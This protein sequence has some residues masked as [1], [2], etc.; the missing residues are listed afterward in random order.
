ML[1]S[2]SKFRFPSK[3]Q[4]PP[5]SSWQD[6]KA[7][8]VNSVPSLYRAASAAASSS[9]T[10]RPRRTLPVKG[11]HLR[12]SGV[13]IL[14]T[15]KRRSSRSWWMK[16]ASRRRPSSLSSRMHLLMS[17]NM[18]V[19]SVYMETIFWSRAKPGFGQIIHSGFGWY[20]LMAS[21]MFRNPVAG[22]PASKSS[23]LLGS[24]S[25]MHFMKTAVRSDVSGLTARRS[26]R[27][28]LGGADRSLPSSHAGLA[29]LLGQQVPAAKTTAR[30]VAPARLRM[31]PAGLPGAGS[32]NPG[33]RQQA[34]WRAGWGRLA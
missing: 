33:G 8:H 18:P 27:G 34:G 1:H 24:Y 28:N 4:S 7:G 32:R 3:G 2:I 10:S 29:S 11:L 13:Q 17:W 12:P 15:S 25:S 9:G 22:G 16:G 31:T 23:E 5:S 20:G 19:A 21:D 26:T 6:V 14:A 30:S